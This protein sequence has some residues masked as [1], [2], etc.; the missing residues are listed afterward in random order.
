MKDISKEIKQISHNLE[1]GIFAASKD[2][3]LYI[4]PA[5]DRTFFFFYLHEDHSRI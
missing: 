2:A 5:D 4:Y 3:L 1:S